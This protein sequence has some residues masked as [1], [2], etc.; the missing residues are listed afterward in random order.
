[1]PWLEPEADADEVLLEVD[2]DRC[3]QVAS[4]LFAN[5]PVRDISISEPPL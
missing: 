4:Q 3:V 1:M 5:P 2:A